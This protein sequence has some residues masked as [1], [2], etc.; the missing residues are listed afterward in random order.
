MKRI[1]LFLILMLC[2]TSGITSY[3]TVYP[4]NAIIGDLSWERQNPHIPIERASEHQR[5]FVH[6]TFVID[7][8]LRVTPKTINPIAREAG[9]KQLQ[10]YVDSGS[11]PKHSLA[12]ATRKPRF[13]DNQ[14]TLC[15][16][17][18]LMACTA[19]LAAAQRINESY[20]YAEL[21]EIKDAELIAWQQ[22]SGFTLRELA[23]I[24]P[25]YG[26][27]PMRRA[28]PVYQ[29]KNTLRY[30][31]LNPA[32]Q[33]HLTEAKFE[34]VEH[35]QGTDNIF[36]TYINQFCGVT[37]IKG[38]HIIDHEYTQIVSYK[39]GKNPLLACYFNSDLDIYTS[40]GYQI[41]HLQQG[42]VHALS[43]GYIT[44]STKGKMGVLDT[45]GTWVIQPT[46]SRVGQAIGSTQSNTKDQ[47]YFIA[48]ENG[49]E[50]GVVDHNHK[51]I[52]PLH[53]TQIQQRMNIWVCRKETEFD[54]FSLDGKRIRI[55]GITS[56]APFSHYNGPYLIIQ[57]GKNYGLIDGFGA[58]KI[59]PIYTNITKV[60]EFYSCKN[61]AGTTLYNAEF[62]KPLP[63]NLTY[64]R[65]YYTSF[66]YKQGAIS[67][68]YDLAGNELIAP[69]KDSL[70]EV[71][72]TGDNRAIFGRKTTVG[73]QLIA[74]NGDQL[75]SKCYSSIKAIPN[76]GR[77][78][79]CESD[80]EKELAIVQDDTLEVFTDFKFNR[81]E[82]INSRV[83]TVKLGKG[84]G[85]YQFNHASHYQPKQLYPPTLDTLY[86]IPLR[87]QVAF[88]AKKNN[89][90]GLISFQGKEIAPFTFEK[91][92]VD[93]THGSQHQ[94]VFL[95]QGESWYCYWLD[96]LQLLEVDPSLTQ[97]LNQSNPNEQLD[98]YRKQLFNSAD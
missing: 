57:Q 67:G 89:Q 94:K 39:Y 22:A 74:E 42:S 37:S 45:N 61:E 78:F 32:T 38:E 25:T 17:G 29:D 92:R 68:V 65:R 40:T 9:I 52:I 6:L 10:A 7:S 77:L 33:E 19:G 30:G 49:T 31:V 64:F 55:E 23:M 4:I 2:C 1:K 73:F 79:I 36:K 98:Y 97:L 5:I 16:V 48:S 91:F 60:G 21:L 62:K 3:A 80:G 11:Y 90:F 50:F 66:F 76:Q 85:L 96:K 13:I 20:E 69:T 46:Y 12:F 86:A 70:I 75:S 15:A 59:K 93:Y 26:M 95:K 72:F 34:R 51:R 43:G 71:G 56:I 24:Q 27:I 81:I 82:R 18:H 54:L 14:G 83:Y 41:S 47:A 58:L 88:I 35:L 53:Y 63:E 28:L 8:L 44:V 84:M 87:N